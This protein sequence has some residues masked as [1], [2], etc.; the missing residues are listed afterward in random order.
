MASPTRIIRPQEGFQMDF[1]SSP[2]DIVIGGGAAGSGKTFS[3]LMEPL[4]HKDVPGF[5][6]VIF[7]RTSPQIKGEG[8]L[9]D[10]SMQL[11]P[12][13]KATPRESVLEWIFPITKSSKKT[14]LKFSHLEYD[15]DVLNWQGTQIPFIGFDELTHF[16]KKMFF[17]LL[18]RNRS[19]CGVKPY[20]RATCNPDPDSWV[21]E[22]IAWFINQ[23]TG[24]P[25]PDRCGKLRYF[26]VES[27]NYIWGNTKQEVIDQLPSIFTRAKEASMDVNDFIKSMTFIPGS[28]YDNKEL[29]KVDPAYLGNLLAQD[30]DTKAQLLDGNWKLRSDGSGVFDPLKVRDLFTNFITDRTRKYITCDAARFGRDLMVIFVWEGFQVVR[31]V[32]AKKSDDR[33]IVDLIEKQRREW[34]IPKSNVVVDQDGVGGG[35]VALGGYRGFSGGAAAMKDKRTGVKENYKNTKTQCFY[36]IAERTLQGTVGVICTNENCIL[37]EESNREMRGLSFMLGGK[38]YNVV[39]LIQKQLRAIKKKNPDMDGKKQINDKEEQK[40]ILGM[41]PDFA[42]TFMMREWFELGT[43]EYVL[44]SVSSYV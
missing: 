2:A 37:I 16:T 1:L 25:I 29:L 38:M 44:G 15:K 21:A 40:A 33:M 11:Y 18:G 7:R 24:F 10:T 26:A 32:F 22:F 17:Y 39:E 35:V 3:L 36:R 27:E 5:G 34:I 13:V 4:R 9:W 23:E 8:G 19:V 41:S 6:S 28:I 43:D 12:H 31:I 20:M 30:E 14:K 42:D